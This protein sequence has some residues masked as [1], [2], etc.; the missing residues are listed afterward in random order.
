MRADHSV[1]I[2]RVK[3]FIPFFATGD[4]IQFYFHVA[5]VLAHRDP[6]RFDVTAIFYVVAVGD[7]MRIELFGL[8]L[9]PAHPT[10]EHISFKNIV[11]KLLAHLLFLLAHKKK[12]K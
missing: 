6:V 2:V 10:G 11:A 4:V 5:F 7:V 12:Y 8:A 9:L 1:K 3:S